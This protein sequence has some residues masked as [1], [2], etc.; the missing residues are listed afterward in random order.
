MELDD[1]SLEGH[2]AKDDN[3]GCEFFIINDAVFSK[4]C[5]LGDNVET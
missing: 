5:I 2:W 4:L 1:G 3:L